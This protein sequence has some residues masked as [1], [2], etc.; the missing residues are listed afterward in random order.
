[1]ADRLSVAAAGRASTRPGARRP[2]RP[3]A[4]RRSRQPSLSARLWCL[5]VAE[6]RAPSPSSSLIWQLV[7][8]S[9]WKPEYVLPGPVTVFDRLW[10]RHRTRP[11][12]GTAIDVTLR[13][14]RAGF[15]LAARHRRRRRPG[16]RPGHASLRAAVGSLITG[17]QTMPSIAW[18]PLAILL[19]KLTRG[20]D[21]LRGRARR[22]AVDR[23]R[24]H[25]RRRPHPADPRCGPGGCWARKG[26]TLYRHVILPAALPSFVGGLKQGWAFAWRSLMAGELLVDHRQPAVDRR[27]AADRTGTCR[28]APGADRDR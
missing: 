12:S 13:R 7:V 5:T 17:L 18:F 21:H 26:F 3:R 16:R 8:W 6:A 28:D 25:H 11:S 24:A 10:D 4:R 19:F 27:A 23:Q 2:R 1:M 15:A 20:G 9:G 14:A 22:R